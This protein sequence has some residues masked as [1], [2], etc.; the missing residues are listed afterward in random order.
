MKIR[1]FNGPHTFLA[2]FGLSCPNDLHRLL[3]DDDLEPALDVIASVRA[4][5]QVA[6]KCFIDLVP[7]EVD[8]EF[9]RGF[10]RTIRNA[11]IVGFDIKSPERCASWL[12][13]SPQ[14][15]GRRKEL[16]STKQRVEAA[17]VELSSFALT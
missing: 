8:S 13:D 16:L 1:L 12:Q 17:R 5:F 9:I 2:R 7:L 6:F 3:P 11:L 15:V 14:G 4:Y 10:A